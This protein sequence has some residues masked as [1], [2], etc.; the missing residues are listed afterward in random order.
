VLALEHYVAIGQTITVELSDG[1][2]VTM[3]AVPW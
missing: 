3:T 2:T 1:R